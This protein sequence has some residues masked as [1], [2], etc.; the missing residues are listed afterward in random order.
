MSETSLAII[1]PSLA[2]STMEQAIEFS[3]RMA[4]AM[5]VPQ[6]LQKKP[7]DCLRVILQASRWQMDPFAVA[8]KT[9]V[10]SGK[11]MYE[12]QLVSAVVNARGNLSKRLDYSFAGEGDSRVLTVSGT[13]KGETEPRVIELP[14]TLARKINKNGQMNINPDQQATY[15]GARIWARRHMPELMLGVYT[16]D[17][18]DDTEVNVTPGESP[19]R[20]EAPAR[21]TTGAA[22]AVEEQTAKKKTRT[23]ATTATAV[24]EGEFKMAE[25]PT[26]A[27]PVTTLADKE[28][29]TF[30]C[31]IVE[32]KTDMIDSA[33]VSHPSVKA[34]IDGEFTGQVFH[35]G[36]ATKDP[37]GDNLIANPAYQLDK[38][39]SVTLI[40]KAR[41]PSVDPTTKVE[42]P[43]PTAILVESIKIHEP[44]AQ[45]A[46]AA[47]QAAVGGT[48]EVD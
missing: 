20:A 6:H 39:V 11:L 12:G 18:I 30:I 22:A 38:P 27:Q 13:I 34:R 40:G 42:T 29:R 21:A 41:K 37:T 3:E 23:K 5:L 17:E 46:P 28:T 32:Y 45:T 31:S 4:Q 35:I 43:R 25:K 24:V 26:P 14:F 15:I 33:G 1:P 8:D 44:V 19:P 48:S 36:G 7:A 9:S 47:D 16:P 2:P 10:I